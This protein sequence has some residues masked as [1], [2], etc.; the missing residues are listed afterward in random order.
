MKTSKPKKYGFWSEEFVRRG[1][2]TAIW[3]QPDG[4]EV[5]ICFI[6]DSETPPKTWP[7]L[8]LVGEV[9][10]WRRQGQHSVI[11]KDSR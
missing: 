5:E 4:S 10:D 7:D 1:H 6:S 8:T 2:R 9:T 3:S 11:P